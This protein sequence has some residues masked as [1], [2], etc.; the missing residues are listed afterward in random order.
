VNPFTTD[1]PLWPDPPRSRGRD[2]LTSVLTVAVMLFPFVMA[3]FCIT[4]GE[5]NLDTTATPD[6]LWELFVGAVFYSLIVASVVVALYQL[7]AY[8]VREVWRGLRPGRGAS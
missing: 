1:H 6:P 4:N 5:D 3:F 7:T 8:I 2:V